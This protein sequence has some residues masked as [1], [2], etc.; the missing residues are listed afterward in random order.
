M[1][2]AIVPLEILIADKFAKFEGVRPSGLLFKDNGSKHP[3]PFS[4]FV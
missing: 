1:I 3:K 2:K 4:S